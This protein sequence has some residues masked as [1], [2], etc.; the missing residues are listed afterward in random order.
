MASR[1]RNLP[2]L[3]RFCLFFFSSWLASF[4]DKPGETP[5][6]WFAGTIARDLYYCWRFPWYCKPSALGNS[7]FPKKRISCSLTL[8]LW[9]CKWGITFLR[10]SSWGSE[11]LVKTSRRVGRYSGSF[12]IIFS[13]SVTACSGIVFAKLGK[14]YSESMAWWI[15]SSS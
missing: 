12:L 3:S 2:I 11:S 8:L 15:S 13:I 4:L 10:I 6:D 9:F 14:T 7:R 5:S 1:S